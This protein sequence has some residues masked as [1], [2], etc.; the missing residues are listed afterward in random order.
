MTE[1]HDSLQADLSALRPQPVSA[2][3]RRR[4]AERLAAQPVP[5]RRQ[6]TWRRALAGSLA[7]ASLA[8]IVG[9]WIFAWMG[10]RNVNAPPELARIQPGIAAEA[11]VAPPTLLAYQRALARSPEELDVLLNRH[12]LATP[13]PEPQPVPVG[14]FTRSEAALHALLGD[15]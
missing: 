12:A 2:E 15:D 10:G 14:A 1:K 9:W 11:D 4:I 6:W 5:V 3:L 13:Y 8:A 7:A